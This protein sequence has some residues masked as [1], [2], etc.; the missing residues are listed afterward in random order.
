MG[1]PF[2][3]LKLVHERLGHGLG[4]GLGLGYPFII[5]KQ[6]HIFRL[7]FILDLT[8]ALKKS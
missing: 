5:S 3:V 2:R 1:T 6:W 7:E 8:V 4:L